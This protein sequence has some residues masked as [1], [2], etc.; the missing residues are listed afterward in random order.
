VPTYDY[1]CHDCGQ[2]FDKRMSIAAYSEGVTPACS[3]CGSTNVARSFATVNVL[4][5]S[6]GSSGSGGST[7]CGTGGFT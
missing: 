2:R 6:R 7:G 4:T 5:G 1:L 3:A